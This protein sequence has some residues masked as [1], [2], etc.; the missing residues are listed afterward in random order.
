MSIVILDVTT[1]AISG[2]RGFEFSLLPSRIQAHPSAM[3]RERAPLGA[4]LK[5][6]K[7]IKNRTELLSL[8]NENFNSL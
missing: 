7:V 6:M 3:L 8:I 1:L 5:N 4:Y 2:L